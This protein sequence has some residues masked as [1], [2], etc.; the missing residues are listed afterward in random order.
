MEMTDRT[1]YRAFKDASA[2]MDDIFALYERLYDLPR[3]THEEEVIDSAL[4]DYCLARRYFVNI[5]PYTRTRQALLA[6]ALEAVGLSWRIVGGAV[7]DSFKSNFITV[8]QQHIERYVKN[9]DLGE[10]EP[11]ALLENRFRYGDQEHIHKGLLFIGRVR[12][13][14]NRDLID[15][16]PASRGHFVPFSSDGRPPRLPQTYQQEAFAKACQVAEK[17]LALVSQDDEIDAN[18]R[19]RGRYVFHGAV[20]KP[21]MKAASR[22]FGQVSIADFEKKVEEEI[23]ESGPSS[24]FDIACGENTSLISLVKDK[25]IDTFVG[26]DISWSQIELIDSSFDGTHLETTTESLFSLIMMVED[27]RLPTEPL[28]FPSVRTFFT[29][30]PT[31]NL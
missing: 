29:T 1:V 31:A 21:L 7:P 11:V 23:L 5:L 10:V 14:D 28:M 12:N 19:F 18:E 16:L 22:V 6:P 8:A 15:S 9:V 4:F 17:A 20:V 24:V 27:S 25:R 3:F 2:F 30:C 26:N 13:Y